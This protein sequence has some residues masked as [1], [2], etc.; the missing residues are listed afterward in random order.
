MLAGNTEDLRQLPLSPRKANLARSLSRPVE[1]IFVA[2]HEQGDIGYDLFRVACTMGLE[3]V[4]SKRL[5]RACDAGKRNHWL[6]VKNPAHPAWSLSRKAQ[7]YMG[8][9]TTM[10]K[11]ETAT[12]TVLTVA[13]ILIW[14]AVAVYG[15]DLPIGFAGRL[16]LAVALMLAA[17]AINRREWWP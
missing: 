15:Q 6:E 11:Y 5:D 7:S 17:M 16:I 4:V 12:R 8:S 9:R 3:G 10:S 1:G 13:L 2:E 14:L